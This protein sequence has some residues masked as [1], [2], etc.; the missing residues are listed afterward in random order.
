M[1]LSG[2]RQLLELESIG[3]KSDAAGTRNVAQSERCKL[4][5]FCLNGLGN[6]DGSTKQKVIDLDWRHPQPPSHFICCGRLI[7]R[8]RCQT[9]RMLRQNLYRLS[10]LSRSIL[11][12]IRSNGHST[13]AWHRMRHRGQSIECI[14]KRGV[15]P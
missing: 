8:F 6:I 15:S 12:S 11:G 1:S 4:D 10:R 9:S 7:C 2:L 3:G 13:L 5:P 14:Y